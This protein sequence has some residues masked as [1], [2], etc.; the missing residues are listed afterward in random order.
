MTQPSPAASNAA[1]ALLE[2]LHFAATKHSD[3]RRKD[4]A[5]SPYINHPIAVARL[6][7]SEGGVT[8]LVTLQGAILHDTV[9]DTETTPEEL[10]SLFGPEVRQVVDE[11]T[12][13]KSL[14]KGDR[15]RLQIEHAPHLSHRAQ[16]IKIA[17]KTANVQDITASPPADWS[18]ERRREYLAWAEQVVS[19][20]RGC[21]PA[22]EA[23]YDQVIARGQA[24]LADTAQPH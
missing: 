2:A 19:G 15:K 3:Q 9:E 10:E 24:A 14:P 6:L 7:A 21:N 22:L 5:A 23:F 1:A 18:T 13:D 16:Q 11:V 12:D 17:D 8:D 20:C 4:R